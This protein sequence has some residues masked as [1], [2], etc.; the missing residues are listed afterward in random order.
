MALSHSIENYLSVAHVRYQ[1][2]PHR[3]TETAFDAACSAHVSASSV[4]KAVVLRDRHTQD[5]AM[6]LMPAANRLKLSW[7]PPR[8]AHMQLAGED[9]FVRMFPDCALG[10]VPGF[11]QAF[12]MDMVWDEELL[13]RDT[14]YFE[15]GDHEALI[16]IDQYD[17]RDLFGRY[18]H[19]VISLPAPH[20]H[21]HRAALGVH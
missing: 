7:L 12:H 1:V 17:F 5:F 13:E 18:D 14:L 3:F 2:V 6:A 11:G 21:L 15:G 16:R 4:V 9:E 19:A 10:A 8:Y 20:H